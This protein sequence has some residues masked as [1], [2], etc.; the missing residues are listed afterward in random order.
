ML[1]SLCVTGPNNNGINSP[2]T[3]WTSLHSVFR[4]ILDNIWNTGFLFRVGG[5]ICCLRGFSN[6]RI[7]GLSHDA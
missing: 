5:W 3:R 6:S 7:A 1:D 2:G 4:Q